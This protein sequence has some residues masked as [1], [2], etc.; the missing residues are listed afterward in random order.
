MAG[1]KLT[2]RTLSEITLV[3]SIAL[4]PDGRKAILVASTVNEERQAR[5]SRLHLWRADDDAI[6]PLTTG[7]TDGAPVWID[8]E[9]FLFT[10]SQREKDFEQRDKPFPKT[11]IYRM[12]LRGGEPTLLAE[13]DGVASGLAPS[14][15]GKKLALVFAQNP[16]FKKKD[17]EHWEKAPP[18]HTGHHA[19]YKL[20][21][22]GFLAPAYPN[23]FVARMKKDGLGK[24]KALFPQP[25]MMQSSPAWLPDSSGIVFKEWNPRDPGSENVVRMHRLGGEGGTLAAP[26]GPIGP[27]AV[28]PDGD[29]VAFTG[30]GDKKRGGMKPLKLG[31]CASDPAE[32]YCEWIVE[33]DGR[34]GSQE[35]LTDIVG[36]FGG[37]IAWVS[38]DTIFAQHSIGGRC[39]LLRVNPQTN[40]CEVAAGAAGL[41]ATFDAAADEVMFVHADPNNVG[42]VYRLGRVQPL[43]TWNR[44]VSTAFSVEP[45]RWMADSADGTQVDTYLWATAKQLA[46]RK[47]A[48]LPLVL[49]VHGGPMAM[50]GEGPF[51]EFAWLA[52]QGYPVVIGNPRG[53]TGYGAD[54]GAAIYG[55]W[56]EKDVEDVL[57]IRESTLAKYPQFDPDRVFLAGGSYGGYMT[58][59]LL[60]RRPGLF[61]GGVAQRVVSNFVSMSG[62]SDMANHIT[63]MAVGLGNVF[64]NPQHAWER[65]PISKLP[66]IV[67]PLLLIHSDQ[68]HRCPVGQAEEV[69]NGLATMGR[70]IDE[71][72]RLVIFRGESHGLSRGGKPENRRVRLREILAWLRKHDGPRT[73]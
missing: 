5:D 67:D 32:P 47:K 23:V 57:A 22:T 45:R 52:E 30:N 20:D 73:A 65:S 54:H 12:S 64:E 17:A 35:V 50:A 25:G 7:P 43:T 58:L 34:M 69:F 62:T 13:V 8:S 37:R 24:P 40:A 63:E 9:S 39:E 66:D 56:G 14:P 1:K 27:L 59:Y 46:T 29:R 51:H 68:D 48:S 55:N 11:R 6:D 71:E 41:V 31:V 53:S 21:G 19:W 10:A 42:E 15:D 49:Y 70:K 33:T 61:R 36:S 26:V 38:E 16:T 2:L 4:S 28:S 60:S 44:R 18:P 3:P 72:V